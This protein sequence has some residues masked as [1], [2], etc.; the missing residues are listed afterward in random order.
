M[1]LA[2]VWLYLYVTGTTDAS[3]TEFFGLW[4]PVMLVES[5]VEVFALVPM[6]ISFGNN[7]GQK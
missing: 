7:G 2:L 6:L 1:I 5:L 3:T 4:F